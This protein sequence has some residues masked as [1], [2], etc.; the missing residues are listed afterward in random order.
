MPLGPKVQKKVQNK[1]ANVEEVES[2]PSTHV[3]TKT[4]V[5]LT[6]VLTMTS[7]GSIFALL[8]AQDSDEW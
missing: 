5:E 8:T 3:Q 1:R 7:D 4:P 6:G 2:P